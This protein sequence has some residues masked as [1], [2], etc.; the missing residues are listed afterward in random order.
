[1]RKI[2][3]GLTL[4]VA[5]VFITGCAIVYSANKEYTDGTRVREFGLLSGVV[6]LYRHTNAKNV[7]TCAEWKKAWKKTCGKCAGECKCA[8]ATS[9][10]GA[11][12]S[13]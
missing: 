3:I 6:P 10:E 4:I 5:C 7:K 1:M 9:T 13:R 12:K 2:L 11:T 8:A